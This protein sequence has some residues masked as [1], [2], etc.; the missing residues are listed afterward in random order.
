ML[1]SP[2]RRRT[3]TS[4][5][6]GVAGQ[7]VLV[8]S[9]TLV[10]RLLG[11][12]DRGSFALLALIPTAI[13]LVGV[14]GLP[15]A[16]TYEIARA[17]RGDGAVIR[18]LAKPAL[19][20]ASLLTLLHGFVLVCLSRT[21]AYGPAVAAAGLITLPLTAAQIVFTYGQAVLQGQ[22]RLG[23]FNLLR[24]APSVLYALLVV[25]LFI[26][27]ADGLVGVCT[28]WL[29]GYAVA[30]GGSIFLILRRHNPASVGEAPSVRVM[31]RFGIKAFVGSTVPLEAFRV[32]QAIVA[33]F[34]SPRALGL[35]VVGTAF[36]N[37]PR[38]LAVGAGLVAYPHVAGLRRLAD[39]RRTVWRFF[40]LTSSACAGF[41][42]LLI[43]LSDWLVPLFFGQEF[44]QAAGVTQLLLVGVVFLCARRILT[45]GLRGAGMPV[46]GTFAEIISW[47][48]LAPAVAVLMPHFEERGVAAAMA[49]AMLAS[50]FYA[51]WQGARALAEPRSD[52]RRRGG[53]GYSSASVDA[54]AD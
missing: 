18:A 28:A 14:F 42:L 9:G 54:R 11:V 6:A 50:F 17:P 29:A 7:T 38:F 48:V 32:D 21:T 8:V 23:S 46:V 25:P 37:L 39:I 20:Q 43:V 49:L 35:Y 52:P 41:A 40:W 33:A 27:D 30:A 2:A 31:S 26:T 47:V 53:A 10:A 51:A 24:L 15:I 5:G 4:I 16:A 36:T 1:G 3:V 22:G 34:L 13:A 45:D 19:L 12:E 44:A